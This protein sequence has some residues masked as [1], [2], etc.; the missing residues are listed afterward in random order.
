MIAYPATEV[1][2]SRHGDPYVSPVAGDVDRTPA[3]NVLVLDSALQPD[4]EVY[5]LGKNYSRLVEL[6]DEGEPIPI[7]SLTSKI[8]SYIYRAT[9]IDRLPGQ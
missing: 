1:W 2:D 8:G 4:P 6:P 3:G 9:A 7:W 5:D